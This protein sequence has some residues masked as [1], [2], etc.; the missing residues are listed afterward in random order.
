MTRIEAAAEES[1]LMEEI[2][3]LDQ[4]KQDLA[5]VERTNQDLQV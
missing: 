2:K 4:L 3:E 1:R 5:K